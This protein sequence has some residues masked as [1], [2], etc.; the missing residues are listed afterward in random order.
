MIRGAKKKAVDTGAP[1]SDDL[2]NIFKDRK[3]P[4]NHY[5]QQL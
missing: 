3:D 2:I 4:V 5:H 1:I